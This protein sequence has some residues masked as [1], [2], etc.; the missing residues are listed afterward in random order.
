MAELASK[1]K[2]LRLH[3]RV[4]MAQ[5]CSAIN[6]SKSTY[7]NYEYGT[8]TP[9]IEALT[10]LADFYGITL[11][12]LVGR[13]EVDHVRCVSDSYDLSEDERQFLQDF[14]NLPKDKRATLVDGIHIIQ[15][16]E[17]SPPELYEET[18]LGEI[19]DRIARQDGE[20]SKSNAS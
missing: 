14:L 15:S 4:T 16:I 2:S 8:R 6:M 11:D 1:L 9:T 7:Q 3:N 12:E 5:L 13:T 20:K 17:R 18:T 10:K 19:E